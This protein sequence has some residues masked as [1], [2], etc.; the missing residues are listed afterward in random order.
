MIAHAMGE[1]DPTADRLSF[2]QALIWLAPANFDAIL[3]IPA[4]MEKFKKNIIVAPFP[5]NPS[6]SE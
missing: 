5:P 2:L 6:V 4:R 1:D 3:T